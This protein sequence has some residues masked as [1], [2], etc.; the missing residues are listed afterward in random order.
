MEPN[1][2]KMNT[3]HTHPK[4]PPFALVV[5]TGGF[6]YAGSPKIEEGYLYLSDAKCIRRWGTERGLGQLATQGPQE[7]TI[8]DPCA[9]VVA[10]VSSLIHLISCTPF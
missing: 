4:L 5:L 2:I 9:D 8:T 7:K 1:Q 10:P 3:T 6:V